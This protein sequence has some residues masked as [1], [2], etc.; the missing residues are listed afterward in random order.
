MRYNKFMYLAFIF[1]FIIL[2]SCSDNNPISDDNQENIQ[3]IVINA[4]TDC[5]LLDNVTQIISGLSS[6]Q[7]YDVT[8]NTSDANAP[9]KGLFF[10]Y[11]DSGNKVHFNYTPTGGSFS[12][13]PYPQTRQIAPIY[14]DWGS[15]RL[16]FQILHLCY[17]NNVFTGSRKEN[18][19]KTHFI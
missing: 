19:W 8:V 7:Y 1:A 17:S 13:K 6:Q 11:I 12:F 18:Y 14:E 15:I 4:K 3:T 9:M 16:S 10:M 5:I 2:S